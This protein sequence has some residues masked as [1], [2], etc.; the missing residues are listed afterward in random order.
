[1]T[2]GIFLISAAA[3]AAPGCSRSRPRADVDDAHGHDHRQ[4]D[5]GDRLRQQAHA[6]A[7]RQALAV[8]LQP[9]GADDRR[10]AGRGR[11]DQHVDRLEGAR[12]LPREPVPHPLRLH[13][14]GGGQQR[15]GEEAVARQRLEILRALAQVGQVQRRASRRW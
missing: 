3:S 14:P 10:D 4:A 1:L 11:R 8:D 13:D 9:L 6:G 5:A 2:P 7:G 15:T 12:Q